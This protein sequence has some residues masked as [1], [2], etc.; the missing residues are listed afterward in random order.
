M[1]QANNKTAEAYSWLDIGKGPSPKASMPR[2]EEELVDRMASICQQTLEELQP[3]LK[4][5]T[6]V[7]FRP[8]LSLRHE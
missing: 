6:Q 3:V 7:C 4:Q 2:N 1:S 8:F 5:I